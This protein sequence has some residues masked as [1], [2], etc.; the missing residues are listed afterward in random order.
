MA[1]I[2]FVSR[3][4]LRI[5]VRIYRKYHYRIFYAT[6]RY[7][8]LQ[9]ST[10]VTFLQQT[11]SLCFSFLVP[12]RK[13]ITTLHM[14]H[15]ALKNSSDINTS[16]GRCFRMHH[17]GRW[18]KNN[19]TTRIS[20][21]GLIYYFL[22]IPH[23]W[24]IWYLPTCKEISSMISWFELSSQTN[25]ISALYARAV[26]YFWNNPFSCITPYVCVIVTKISQG[27]F[28]QW[29]TDKNIMFVKY[30]TGINMLSPSFSMIVHF[31][32]NTC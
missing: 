1:E 21:K 28:A 23:L 10:F 4:N 13:C 6:W 5:S 7:C 17:L 18:C 14:M 19:Y 2:D 8:I 32:V 26:M 16:N 30:A 25:H 15:I 3:S 22:I 12:V 31:S 27:Y 11:K 24:L 20:K 9:L 29:F